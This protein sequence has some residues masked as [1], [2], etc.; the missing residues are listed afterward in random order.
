MDLTNDDSSGN[1]GDGSGSSATNEAL[2][3][4]TPTPPR[5]D[6]ITVEEFPSTCSLWN[7]HV[8][9]LAEEESE[10]PKA[11][12]IYLLAKSE[13]IDV[14]SAYSSKPGEADTL[15]RRY[16][17]GDIS[18]WEIPSAAIASEL[19]N[20]YKA[21]S[22]QFATLNAL[23][24]NSTAISTTS[25]S[26][27]ARYLC[28][29]ATKTFS[30]AEGTSVSK[31]GV[32]KTYFLRP[33]K[34]ILL[35]EEGFKD[36]IS[37]NDPDDETP[38]V[39]DT[40]SG[41]DSGGNTGDTEPTVPTGDAHCYLWHGHIVVATD[42]ETRQG[43]KILT[44]LSRA[45]LTSK[46]ED[47]PYDAQDYAE[48]DIKGWEIPS[49]EMAIYLRNT[50]GVTVNGQ[51][52]DGATVD[53]SDF[54]RLGKIIDDCGELF[55]PYSTNGPTYF[56]CDGGAKKYAFV[57]G[58]NPTAATGKTKKYNLLLTKTITVSDSGFILN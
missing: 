12:K 58:V 26:E 4:G 15:V 24:S 45:I 35:C 43:Y 20:T 5:T 10:L 30:F 41:E 46:I 39:D 54:E 44:L 28:E 49:T 13:F 50:F 42:S 3:T 9:A 47:A 22:N 52:N 6:T 37:D 34:E 8:V 38:E 57:K 32:Q 19:R 7:G 21:N 36:D 31:A 29:N 16:A 25:G 55:V 48:E 51:T 1:K 17:E 40:P 53:M 14:A 27:N 33:V 11:V 23:L 2:A 18:G 56:L